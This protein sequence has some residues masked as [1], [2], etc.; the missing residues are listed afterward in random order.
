MANGGDPRRWLVRP[1][2]VLAL[3]GMIG[4]VGLAFLV[5]ADVLSRFLFAIPV[6]ATENVIEVTIPIVVACCLPSG[7]VHGQDVAIRFL[8]GWVGRM[9]EDWLELFAM[10]ATLVFYIVL[11]WQVGIYANEL[12]ADNRLTAI[13]RLPM[14]P[15]WWG[16]TALLVFAIVAQALV[17]AARIRAYG[18]G[19]FRHFEPDSVLAAG[20]LDAP[21]SPG[22]DSR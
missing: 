12:A 9:A 4:L 5:V 3:I 16:T 10:L 7:L 17:I 18:T 21:A 15:F 20:V 13:V 1:T 19:G 6:R 14:S 8:G 11:T 22:R 2:N